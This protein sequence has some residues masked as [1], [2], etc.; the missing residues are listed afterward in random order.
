MTA[1]PLGFRIVGPCS[2][3]RRLVDWHAAFRAYCECDPRARVDAEAYLS[4]FTFGD[5]FAAHLRDTG[6]TR[7][8]AGRCGAAWLWFDI[9][10]D[11]A[12]GG[13]D[14]ALD[15]A[16]KLAVALADRYGVDDGGQLWFYSGSKGFHCGIPTAL[17]NPP[18]S[19]DFHRIARRLAETIAD[20]AGVLI[21]TGVYDKVRAFRA[22]N[23]PHPATGRHK[24]RFI[25]DELL[26]LGADSILKR[27]E[28]PEPLELPDPADAAVD[29][30]LSAT[31]HDATEHVRAEATAA[32][33]RRAADGNG[34][35]KLN[36][37]TLEFIRGGAAVGDRHR[38]LY[39]AARNLAEFGCSPAL[40]NA[41][42]ADAALDCGLSPSD[43]RRQIECGIADTPKGE[44]E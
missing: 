4:A 10:R 12:A 33:Q 42:L 13:I 32:E 31:W 19:A 9:D 15:D 26:H 44:C 29:V 37:L 7:G 36:R 20:A 17:W 16:R 39:S 38:L 24:R 28:K 18:P 5:D 21:D 22:P 11:Q 40:A 35:V 8:F 30:A 6:S 43:V 25:T 27:A 14:A 23:S 41:L 3:E 2:A 34:C 1:A